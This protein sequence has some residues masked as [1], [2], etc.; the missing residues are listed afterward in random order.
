MLRIPVLANVFFLCLQ[1]NLLAE[2]LAENVFGFRGTH[3]KGIKPNEFSMSRAREKRVRGDEVVSLSGSVIG[4]S[5]ETRVLV[6]RR[7]IRR[8]MAGS[9]SH[10]K[11]KNADGV[12]VEDALGRG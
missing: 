8:E 2:N 3:P 11:G 10:R 12:N 5:S 4:T 6:V 7:M 9:A 1:Q